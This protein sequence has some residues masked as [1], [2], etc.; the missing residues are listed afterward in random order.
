M[1]AIQIVVLSQVLAGVLL[2]YSTLKL[3][4]KQIIGTKNIRDRKQ[5]CPKQ[6]H[7]C[8]SW[9]LSSK[10]TLPKFKPLSAC[11]DIY[12]LILMTKSIFA[13]GLQYK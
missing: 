11:S 3:S 1:I 6:F 5:V 8:R 7:D 13:T 2:L 12:T 9:L 10:T 4:K